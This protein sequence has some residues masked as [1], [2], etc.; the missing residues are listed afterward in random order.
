MRHAFE[1]IAAFSTQ[2]PY[3]ALAASPG[4]RSAAERRDVVAQSSDFAFTVHHMRAEQARAKDVCLFIAVNTEEVLVVTLRGLARR[5]RVQAAAEAG[6][7]WVDRCL[8]DAT[9]TTGAARLMCCLR[10]KEMHAEKLCLYSSADVGGSAPSAVATGSAAGVQRLRVPN[11]PFALHIQRMVELRTVQ[12]SPSVSRLIVEV[13]VRSCLR[14]S[15]VEANGFLTSLNSPL[16]AVRVSTVS[17]S[18]VTLLHRFHASLRVLHLCRRSTAVFHDPQGMMMFDDEE[19]EEEET[20]TSYLSYSTPSP[21]AAFGRLP[22]LLP[23]APRPPSPAKTR[24]TAASTTTAGI[25]TRG[26][27]SSSGHAARRRR[28]KRA[29]QLSPGITPVLEELHI[30][31]SIRRRLPNWLRQCP[32]LQRL[33]LSGCR[34]GNLDALRPAVGLREV[35]LES[36]DNFTRFSFFCDFP[37]LQAL[38]IK[39]CALLRSIAWLPRLSGPLCS[40]TLYHLASNPLHSP[41]EA[42]TIG[43]GLDHVQSLSLS[44]PVMTQLRQLV[45]HASRT[46][47]DLT[48]FTCMDVEDFAD[49][50]PL[51]SLEKVCIT[52]N[53]HMQSFEWLRTSPRL[54]EVRATQCLQLSSLAGLSGCRQLRVLELAGAQQLQDISDI[55]NCV[56]L[57]YVDLSHCILMTDVSVLRHLPEL[58]CVLLRNCVQ[59]SRDFGWLAGC[60]ALVDLMVPNAT[61]YDA[62]NERLQQLNRSGSVLLH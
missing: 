37:Q 44:I 2:L 26:S 59:L 56:A 14:W 60:P 16:R 3:A 11:A 33:T 17:L 29:P 23:P 28:N 30:S 31:A 18:A 51:P 1:V 34:Y 15:Q 12:L 57:M 61:W 54:T 48:L 8:H 50:P 35:T 62:A 47:R 21:G 39:S 32:H 36:C 41:E 19:L 24:R 6:M 13:D 46:L 22:P 20:H 52:G 45:T 25:A 49:L 9:V 55:S 27:A 4:L 38:H 10:L 53:R 42:T 5:G 58:N 7:W 43:V 40:L